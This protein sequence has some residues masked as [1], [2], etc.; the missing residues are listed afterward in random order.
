MQQYKRLWKRV[1]ASAKSIGKRPEALRTLLYLLVATS[2]LAL[3][4]QNCQ[5]LL[6]SSTSAKDSPQLANTPRSTPKSPGKNTSLTPSP[7]S[8][9]RPLPSL[10]VLLTLTDE[11]TATLAA[12]ADRRWDGRAWYLE[13]SAELTAYLPPDFLERREEISAQSGVYPKKEDYDRLK[14][15]EYRKFIDTH[16]T[17]RRSIVGSSIALSVPDEFLG[18]NDF[19][20]GVPAYRLKDMVAQVDRL[21][22]S[23]PPQEIAIFGAATPELLNQTHP[24]NILDDTLTL[25]ETIHRKYPKTRIV[26]SSVLPRSKTEQLRDP[27]MADVSNPV[28]SVLNRALAQQFA[29]D[30][31]VEFLDLSPYLI[32]EAGNLKREFSTDGLHPN[33][34]ATLVFLKLLDRS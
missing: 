7:A 32:D 26:F 15:A 16:P 25:I 24:K 17:V 29:G 10:E 28:V 3:I 31:R 13:K 19:N 18:E 5:S 11:E 27:R 6:V 9:P 23:H 8:T 22:D 14:I 1:L 20:L 21:S 4:F 30:D 34:Q 12:I 2:G 33:V